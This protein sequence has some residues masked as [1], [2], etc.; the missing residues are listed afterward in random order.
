MR[1]RGPRSAFPVGLPPYHPPPMIR[2][3]TTLL[4]A[5]WL[6][7]T[8]FAQEGDAES[9]VSLRAAFVPTT[10]KPGEEVLLRITLGIADGWHLYGRDEEIGAPP[11]LTVKEAAGLEAVGPTSVPLGEPHETAGILSYWVTGTA[12]VEQKFRVPA[13]AAGTLA[14]EGVVDFMVCDESTCLPPETRAFRTELTVQGAEKPKATIPTPTADQKVTFG[15]RIEPADVAPGGEAELVV[16]LRIFPGWHVYGALEEVGIPTS[17]SLTGSAVEKVGAASVPDG[18]RHDAGGF[19]S[20]W[21]EGEMEIRQRFRVPADAQ[22]GALA[23]G[24]TVD[25]M[26]CDEASC[27]P[28]GQLVGE[29]TFTVAARSV[30]MIGIGGA[31]GIATPTQDPFGFGDPAPKFEARFEPERSRAGETVDLVVRVSVPDGWHV[32]GARD[33]NPIKVS[34]SGSLEAEGPN[35]LPDGKLHD[36]AGLENYWLTGEFEIRQA[37]RVP[38]DAKEGAQAVPFAVDYL[39]CDESTCLPPASEMLELDLVVEAGPARSEYGGVG[40]EEGGWLALLLGAVAA[41]LFALLMPCTYPMIPLTISMFTKQAEA[42][43]GK[44]LPVSLTYGAGIVLS[45]VLIGEL[46]GPRIVP[47]ATHPVTNGVIAVAFLFFAMSL[48]GFITL[49]PPRFLMNAAGKAQTKGGYIGVLLMGATLVITSF[50]CTVPFVASLLALAAQGGHA[51]TIVGMATFGLTMAIP[52]VILSLL[53]SRA[54]GIPRAGEW[55]NQLKVFMGF[56][57]L[58][59]A[60]KFVSNVDVVLN[61]GPLW[62][63]RTTFLWSWAGIFAAA[64]AYLGRSYLA[65][66]GRR[67]WKSA[68]GTLATLALAAWCGFGATGQDLDPVLTAIAPPN[69]KTE[70]KA[71]HT[72]VKDDYQL[73]LD[74]AKSAGQLVF[75]NFTGFT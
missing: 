62:L 57:E 13:A 59:A 9:K 71:T 58:A 28:P 56:V 60:L 33:E 46:V 3:L 16:D 25:Y 61:D 74:T 6:A 40:G 35:R 67:T 30:P 14:L 27:D 37:Y 2:L 18:N 8:G 17:L 75:V 24:F 31:M 73:A 7:Q 54:R 26:T 68:A 64:T 23:V 69:S 21:V 66:H 44:V 15:A 4:A 29:A 34:S 36:T 63:S 39:L 10:A 41:G 45:F 72:I 19:E 43:G 55:M 53:P 70:S 65:A 51:Q 52:F 50:T 42:R 48:F 32:Y 22:P 38:S 12:V 47:F 49:E 11:S 5:L 20:Y 1:V